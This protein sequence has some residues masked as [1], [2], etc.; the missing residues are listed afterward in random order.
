M[1]KD[2][3]LSLLWLRSLLWQGFNPQPRKFHKPWAQPEGKKEKKEER[4]KERKE[5]RKK[6]RNS[7]L[8][9]RLSVDVGCKAS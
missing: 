6:G 8:H 2:L 9:R 1:V 7:S 3:A 4:K 5:G